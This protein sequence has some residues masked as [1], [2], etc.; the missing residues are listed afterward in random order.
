VFG[1]TDELI[2]E[3]KKHPGQPIRIWNRWT[4]DWDDNVEVEEEQDGTI[5]LL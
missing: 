2:E 3:L 1:T 4:E 5:T